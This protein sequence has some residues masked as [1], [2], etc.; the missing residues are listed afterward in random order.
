MSKLMLSSWGQHCCFMPLDPLDPTPSQMIYS[1][2]PPPL[3][4]GVWTTGGHLLLEGGQGCGAGPPPEPLQ[5]PVAGD[6]LPPEAGG[7]VRVCVP[8]EV[9]GEKQR[10][11]REIAASRAEGAID[12]GER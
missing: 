2:F 12:M 10:E 5:L 4:C 9:E 7:E 11:R 3:L 6:P 8:F 1:G